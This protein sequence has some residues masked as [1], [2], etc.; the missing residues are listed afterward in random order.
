MEGEIDDMLDKP[1]GLLRF[2]KALLCLNIALLRSPSIGLDSSLDQ[3]L[4]EENFAWNNDWKEPKASIFCFE[5]WHENPCLSKH[6]Y[7]YL[8]V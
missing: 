5:P 3:E 1:F 6:C 2:L 4:G 7:C 8:D